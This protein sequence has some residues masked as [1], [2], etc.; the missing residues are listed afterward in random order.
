LAFTTNPIDIDIATVNP[1]VNFTLEVS[2]IIGIAILTF[3]SFQIFSMFIIQIFMLCNL[4][5]F[6][7]FI[8][9]YNIFSYIY[10]LKQINIHPHKY[11]EHLHNR[12]KY[13]IQYFE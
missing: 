11:F 8:F 7:H 1:T 3:K 2:H 12:E 10:I 6:I 9:T 13:K 5:P 4:N